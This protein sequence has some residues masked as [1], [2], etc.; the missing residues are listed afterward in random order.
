MFVSMY[1]HTTFYIHIFRQVGDRVGILVDRGSAWVYVN[2]TQA[3]S[4]CVGVRVRVCVCVRARARVGGWVGECRWV[5]ARARVRA[6]LARAY[7]VGP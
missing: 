6:R 5:R 4:I 1:V 7:E 2:G 3:R